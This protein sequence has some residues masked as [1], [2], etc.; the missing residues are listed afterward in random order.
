MY[1]IGTLKNRLIAHWDSS[2]EHIHHIFKLMDKKII[3]F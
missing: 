3:Q 2:F 1:V